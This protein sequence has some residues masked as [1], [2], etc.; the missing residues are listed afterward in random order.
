[1]SPHCEL[2]KPGLCLSAQGTRHV[3][4]HDICVEWMPGGSGC[5]VLVTRVLTKPCLTTRGRSH[6]LSPGAWWQRS[7]G[8]CSMS[9]THSCRKSGGSWGRGG[10]GW[11]RGSEQR[12]GQSALREQRRLRPGT[13]PGQPSLPP[14][15]RCRHRQ[16]PSWEPLRHFS[17]C[18][19]VLLATP[20]TTRSPG[21][22]PR[23]LAKC[24]SRFGG[25]RCC[26]C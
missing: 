23:A 15:P 21:H 11:G 8:S 7:V 10:V 1:M 24:R 6:T 4:G 26:C 13:G 18:P 14:P 2:L 25:S 17:L 16:G 20:L 9:G 19:G 3:V 5:A 22:A 12:H